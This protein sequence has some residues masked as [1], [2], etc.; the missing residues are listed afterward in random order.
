MSY[1]LGFVMEQT[2][3]H[4]THDL[5]LR[6][7]VAKDS[8][9]RAR[10]MPVHFSAPDRWGRIPFIKTNW[11]LRAS[12]R[13]REQVRAVLRSDRLDGLF[14]PTQVT[15]LFAQC[16]MAKIPSVVSLDATPLSFD[17]IGSAYSHSPS[18]SKRVE[19]LKNALNRRTFHLARRLITWCHWTKQSLIRDYGVDAA[20]ITVIPPGIDLNQWHFPREPRQEPGCVRLLFVG[21]DFQRKGGAVLLE[22]FRQ[23]LMSTCEL[24][25][26]TRED[27]DIRGLRGVRVHHGL[28]ANAPELMALFGRA[29]AFV[30]PTFGDAQPVVIAEAMASGLPVIS[31]TIGAIDEQ[32]QHGVTGFLISSGDHRAVSEAVSKL[33]ADPDLRYRMGVAGRLAAERLFDAA[34]NYRQLLAVCKES[35][36]G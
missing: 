15:A 23:D 24:D 6:Q 32:V 20:K 16:L 7:W 26:V 12:L 11:T 33:V 1:T 29:D 22:A 30:F 3:G 9:I 2:L 4:V 34:R 18:T 14:F 36:N 25:I 10:W 5:N 31:T 17:T 8:D 35:V 13:A 21:G 19:A 27:V 28:T